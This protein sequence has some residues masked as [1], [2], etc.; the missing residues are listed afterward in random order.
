MFNRKSLASA[1]LLPSLML[2]ALRNGLCLKG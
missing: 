2:V 1:T